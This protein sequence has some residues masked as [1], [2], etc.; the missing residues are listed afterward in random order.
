MA[1]EQAVKLNGT[2]VLDHK[3]SDS[4]EPF[5]KEM[6]VPWLVIKLFSGATPRWDIE[7]TE[8]GMKHVV[9]SP[10]GATTTDYRFD[11]VVEH[12]AGDGSKHPAT[13]HLEGGK[14]WTVVRHASKGDIET[15]YTVDAGPSG[16]PLLVAIVRLVRGGAEVLLMKRAFVRKNN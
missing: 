16:E 7:I 6:G 15:T 2:W 14:L 8:V 9:H 4:I 11:G 12:T 3:R 5:L 1:A 13:L 10:R